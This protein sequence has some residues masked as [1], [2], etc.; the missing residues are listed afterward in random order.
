[1][2][3]HSNRIY[4]SLIAFV[5]WMSITVLGGRFLGGG[6]TSLSDSVSNS[7]AWNILAAALFLI[8]LIVA[9][10]WK[11]MRFNRPIT[12]TP[13]LLWLPVL[14]LAAFFLM[15][16]AIGL[17]PV[18]SVLFVFFNTLVV[19]FSEETMFRGVLFRAFREKMSIWPSIIIVSV[20]FGSVHI[21][22]F[23]ITGQ[24]FPAV[25]QSIA[26]AMTGVAMMAMLIRTGSIIVPIIYHG[27]FDFGTFMMSN[28]G[29]ATETA[30][31]VPDGLSLLTLLPIAFVLPNFL[32]GL[33]L[34]RNVGKTG[35]PQPG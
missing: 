6:Q 35:E 23:F 11:D 14:Y 2:N 19:G 13:K 32:Y 10:R 27:L 28:A 30:A 29:S 15:T 17:P 18:L 20:M 4:V 24:L 33:Y 25:L 1:M 8:G 34:L 16:A 7:I 5:I 26:A 22:N 12:G 31:T 21:L 3:G 9:L